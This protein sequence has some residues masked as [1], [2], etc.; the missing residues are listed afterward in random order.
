MTRA[1][2]STDTDVFASDASVE[3]FFSVS[4]ITATIDLH[5]VSGYCYTGSSMYSLQ[6]VLFVVMSEKSAVYRHA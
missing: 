1:Q 4:S 2:G 3:R 5:R 6:T